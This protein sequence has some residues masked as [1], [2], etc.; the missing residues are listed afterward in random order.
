[1]VSSKLL[2]S[3]KALN[4]LKFLTVLSPRQKSCSQRQQ[5]WRYCLSCSITDLHFVSIDFF[6]F[7]DD[8]Y[9]RARNF[10]PGAFIF[11]IKGETQSYFNQMFNYLNNQNG[12]IYLHAGETQFFPQGGI[13]N[14]YTNKNYINDNLIHA[15]LLP[16]VKR[17]GH[18]FESYKNN[19]LLSIINKK[20]IHSNLALFPI[21]Y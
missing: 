19:L 2:P 5:R 10:F 18:G 17:I 21:K 12:N 16:G 14:H 9:N 1:M 6:A 8:P 7:K 3:K 13:D 20:N 4:N 11:V 15:A